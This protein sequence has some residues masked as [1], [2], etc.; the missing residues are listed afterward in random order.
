MAIRLGT[1]QSDALTGTA[2]ADVLLGLGGDD[3]LNGAGGRDLLFGGKGNDTYVIDSG[4]FLLEFA[5]GGTDTVVAGFTYMLGA[6]LENLTLTGAADVS[7]TGNA[8]NNVIVGNAGANVMTGVAG[9]DTLDGGVEELAAQ[10]VLFGGDGD[11]RLMF[12][13]DDGQ[14]SDLAY[15]GGAGTDA[16]VFGGSDQ[17]LN[18]AA[19]SVFAI[20][21]VEVIDLSAAGNHSVFFTEGYIL[22]MSST[23]VV[24]V[25]GG[26]G[27]RVS[28]TPDL[29]WIFAGNVTIGGQVY[30]EYQGGEALL[31]VD[32]DIDR[33]G[34][35]AWPPESGGDAPALALGDVLDQSDLL[36]ANGAGNVAGDP[37]SAGAASSAFAPAPDTASLLLQDAVQAGLV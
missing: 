34:I 7:G 18:L 12:N 1:D 29:D 3:T 27:D 16:L 11:D 23:D 17:S 10:D 37:E 32:T 31:R 9:N 8:A 24:Q 21:D 2:S 5:G 35:A 14:S 30:A 28:T 25:E 36:A 22:L 15:D 26:A 19:T 4:D 6:N 20:R 13:S 33:S